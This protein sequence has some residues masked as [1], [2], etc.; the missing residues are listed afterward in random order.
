MG[1][2]LKSHLPDEEPDEH[3]DEQAPEDGEETTL[4][5]DR[6]DTAVLARRNHRR[7]GKADVTDSLSFNEQRELILLVRGMVER[8]VLP[9]KAGIV[10]GRSDVQARYHPDVDL[11][12]YGALDRGVSR[13]HARLHLEDGHLYITDLG[14]TNGTFISGKRLEP[15]KPAEL[16][17]GDELILGRLTVQV[18]FRPMP[19]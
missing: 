4:E 8:L 6:P 9:E 18:L 15:N 16:R 10:L 3:D 2:P 17:K 7:G 19:S 12:P 13:G 11:T 5:S 1:D 14:S